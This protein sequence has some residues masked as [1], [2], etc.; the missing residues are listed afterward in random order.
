MVRFAPHLARLCLAGSV[1]IG[2]GTGTH[3]YVPE[4]DEP[5]SGS[6]L[7]V[8]PNVNVCPVFNQSLV[9]PRSIAPRA[10]AE[11]VVFATDPDGTDASLEFDWTAS[12][13]SFTQ[14]TRPVTGYSCADPGPQVL[15]VRAVDRLGCRVQLD[16]DVTCLDE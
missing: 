2:C 7:Q 10:S 1:L 6:S 16:L 5:D 9:I 3:N 11:V 13:G 4:Q 8:V 15:H 14:P 12:S